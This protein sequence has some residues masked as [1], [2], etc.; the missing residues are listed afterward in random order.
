MTTQ[1]NRRTLLAAAGGAAGL[2]LFGCATP[3]KPVARV[4]V[5][6]GGAGGAPA[7]KYRSYFAKHLS[8]VTGINFEVRNP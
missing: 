4:V 7:A 3:A 8:R 1:W 2:A 6:G 5:I